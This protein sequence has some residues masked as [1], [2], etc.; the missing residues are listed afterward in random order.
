MS[1]DDV[2][3]HGECRRESLVASAAG[4]TRATRLSLFGEQMVQ[5]VGKGAYAHADEGKYFIATN[6]TPGTGIAGLAAADGYDDEQALCIIQNTATAG[7]DVRLYLDYIKLQTTVAGTNGTNVTWATHIDESA[8]Y[9]SGGTTYTPTNLNLDSNETANA[10]VYFGAVVA[11][12]AGSTAVKLGSGNLRTAITVVGDEYTLD[13]GGPR[14]ADSGNIVAGSAI[15][16]LRVAHCPVVLSPQ[17][18][19]ILAVNAASQTV[20]SQ[21]EFEVGFWER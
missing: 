19:L 9:V 14:V 21:F 17:D 20:A 10:T 11:S 12:A 16:K 15:A 1:I 4:V 18:C 13:F 5:A 3:G 2:K 8:R 6:P 7:S